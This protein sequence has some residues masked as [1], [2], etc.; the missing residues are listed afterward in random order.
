[1]YHKKKIVDNN[2]K[3]KILHIQK[4]TPMGISKKYKNKNK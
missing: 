1:M 3:N 2:H 4:V